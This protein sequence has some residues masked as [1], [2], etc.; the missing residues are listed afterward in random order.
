MEQIKHWPAILWREWQECDD[1]IYANQLSFLLIGESR[2]L[3]LPGRPNIFTVEAALAQGCVRYPDRARPWRRLL[4]RLAQQRPNPPPVAKLIK[5]LQG[6]HWTRRFLARHTLVTAGGEAV[7]ALSR[8][9]TGE[10]EALSTLARWLLD[11][12][13]RETKAR[14]ADRAADLL[15]PD[16][17]VSFARYEVDLGRLASMAYYG[18]RKC[19]QSRRVLE[20]DRKVVAV[21]D[22]DWRETRA[23]RTGYLRVNVL[24]DQPLFEFERVEIIKATD[25]QVER[26]VM[27]LAND[28][29]AGR[30]AHYSRAICLLG[31]Q[32]A[33]SQNTLRLLAHT[34]A[35]VSPFAPE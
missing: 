9:T 33:L 8:L 15:C 25:H 23:E 27:L 30:Q 2:G 6:G 12:I 11:N 28:D 17:L 19:G 22:A 24:L 16:C 31:P 10:D 20:T 5:D 32:V 7:E 34:F 29:D 26:F 14:L 13:E 4:R 1:K 3:R 18:C 35:S 21:L